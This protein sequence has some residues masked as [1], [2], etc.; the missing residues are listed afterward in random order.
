MINRKH[1]NLL[2]LSLQI[3]KQD[4]EELFSEERDK[5][6]PQIWVKEKMLVQMQKKNSILQADQEDLF[7]EEL[8]NNKVKMFLKTLE[9]RLVKMSQLFKILLKF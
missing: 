9:W 2:T 8:A 5:W 7:G 6:E 1:K 3:P 4:K